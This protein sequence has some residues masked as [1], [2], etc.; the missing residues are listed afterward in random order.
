MARVAARIRT[1]KVSRGALQ[2]IV[3]VQSS[4]M[5][6]DTGLRTATVTQVSSVSAKQ[7]GRD[8]LAH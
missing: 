7:G 1:R 3:V 2:R 5:A 4:S 6:M 8:E